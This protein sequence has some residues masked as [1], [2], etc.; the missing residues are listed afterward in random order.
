MALLASHWLG[1][2]LWGLAIGFPSVLRP[3][4][5]AVW[6]P[7]LSPKTTTPWPYNLPLSLCEVSARNGT[8]WQASCETFCKQWT[9]DRSSPSPS[10]LHGLRWRTFLCLLH[11]SPSTILCLLLIIL[12]HPPTPC[13]SS[14]LPLCLPIYYLSFSTSTSLI[15][16][17]IYFYSIQFFMTLGLVQE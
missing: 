10:S 9:G 14:C 6:L 5:S 13:S 2:R 17:I 16:I 1:G 4:L 15:I 3:R 11:I 12:T 7:A 8:T